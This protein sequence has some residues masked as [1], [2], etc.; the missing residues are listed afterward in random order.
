VNRDTTVNQAGCIGGP[1]ERGT[2]LLC[3]FCQDAC[4][5]QGDAGSYHYRKDPPGIW[6]CMGCDLVKADR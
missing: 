5:C 2:D 1:H 6:R 4:T 3:R